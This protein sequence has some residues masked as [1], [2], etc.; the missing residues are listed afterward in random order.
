M[1]KA[2]LA[3]VLVVLPVVAF[4][5]TVTVSTNTTMMQP[6]AMITSTGTFHF[7]GTPQI[8]VK[9]AGKTCTWVGSGSVSV[10]TGCNYIIDQDLSGS[11]ITYKNQQDG[12]VC[13]PSAQMA[14]A[15]K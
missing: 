13:T 9:V 15:C 12:N 10:S 11:T 2:F 5:D 3:A 8:V 14:A 1:K 4:A 6:G 7:V